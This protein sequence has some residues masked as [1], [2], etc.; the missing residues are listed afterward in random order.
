M[1]KLKNTESSV[2]HF[3]QIWVKVHNKIMGELNKATES[4]FMYEI[5]F[6]SW[7]NEG[8]QFSSIAQVGNSISLYTET[9]IDSYIKN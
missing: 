4:K 3:S 6:T 9:K 7:D 2:H 8:D 1:E 5:F